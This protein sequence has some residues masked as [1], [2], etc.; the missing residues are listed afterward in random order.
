MS[1]YQA[2][3]IEDTGCNLADAAM[4]E[5][6]MRED[7]FHSTLDWQ[8]RAELR[9]AARKAAKLLEKNRDLYE[10]ERDQTRAVF[11]QMQVE[12]LNKYEDGKNVGLP[13]CVGEFK[14]LKAAEARK[15]LVTAAPELLAALIAVLPHT[16]RILAGTTIG[17]PILAQARAAIAKATR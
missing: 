16:E 13:D 1:S 8:T 17:Q 10:A 4:I 7:I 15:E 3:I 11:E 6:I 12:Q 9:R 5:H 2:M 14:T